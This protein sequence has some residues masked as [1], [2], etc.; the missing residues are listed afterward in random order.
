MQKKTHIFSAF[1][2]MFQIFQMQQTECSFFTAKSYHQHKAESVFL[3][4]N[5]KVRA[6]D[7]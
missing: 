7:V 5:W 4:L 1:L 6:E 2:Y 3:T